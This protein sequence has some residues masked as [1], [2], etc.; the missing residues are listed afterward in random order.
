MNPSVLYDAY[1]PTSQVVRATEKDEAVKKLTVEKAGKQRVV[2]AR[3]AGVS[4][5]GFQQF[6]QNLKVFP[7]GDVKPVNCEGSGHG[8]MRYLAD[9]MVAK[10]FN[11]LVLVKSR[12][13]RIYFV[14]SK[15]IRDSRLLS[16][17]TQFTQK[18]LLSYP[19][20]RYDRVKTEYL[21][22][23]A[24]HPPPDAYNGDSDAEHLYQQVLQARVENRLSPALQTVRGQVRS[25]LD[26]LLILDILAM[27]IEG[28]GNGGPRLLPDVYLVKVRDIPRVTAVF[29][30]PNITEFDRAYNAQNATAFNESLPQNAVSFNRS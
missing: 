8:A 17:L 22:L 16:G 11:S 12:V 30:R 18:E 10:A 20:D 15:Y 1:D 2:V 13:N 6:T 4:T 19:D 5:L 26:Y 7:L 25:S 3:L 23:L 24:R 27:D 29:L 21:R 14:G 9:A 28:I